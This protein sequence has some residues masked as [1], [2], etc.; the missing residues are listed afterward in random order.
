M[1]PVSSNPPVS[2]AAN[3]PS[4]GATSSGTL[5]GESQRTDSGIYGAMVAAWGNAPANPP[6]YECVKIFDSAGQRLIA[7]GVCSGMF[8][9]FR[10]P[11]PPGRYLLDRSLLKNQPGVPPKA[12]PGSIVVDVNPGQWVNL[13]PTPP[14]GPVP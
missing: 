10:I 6:T 5:A 1:G 3:S 7:T 4:A 14:P 11:L 12:Q 8:G 9:Q 13:A 2:L